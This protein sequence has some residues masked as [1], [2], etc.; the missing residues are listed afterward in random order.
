MLR[1]IEGVYSHDFGGELA[2]GAFIVNVDRLLVMFETNAE[3][4]VAWLRTRSRTIEGGATAAFAV[5]ANSSVVRERLELK[6]EEA[7]TRDLV[8]D[9]GGGK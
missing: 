8:G 1:N 2:E 6:F 4:R 5:S 3:V 7:Q 9:E